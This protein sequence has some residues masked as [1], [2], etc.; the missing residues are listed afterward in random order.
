LDLNW[1]PDLA[2]AVIAGRLRKAVLHRIVSVIQEA[3]HPITAV[4]R[5]PFPDQA[6]LSSIQSLRGGVLTVEETLHLVPITDHHQVIQVA[7]GLLQG[8]NPEATPQDHLPIQEVDHPLIQEADH[9]QDH[10]LT[11]HLVHLPEGDRLTTDK[12]TF[13]EIILIQECRYSFTK[14]TDL[15]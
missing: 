7:Q 10:L 13:I 12:T 5:V 1:E 4:R 9:P 2:A 6:M 15:L 14:E 11:V 3:I 8:L